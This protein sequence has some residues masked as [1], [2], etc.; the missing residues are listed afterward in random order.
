MDFFIKYKKIFLVVLFLSITLLLGFLIYTLF[1]KSF[2]TP[3]P[4]ETDTG[5]TT[6]RGEFPDSGQGDGGNII[7]DPDRDTELPTNIDT[8]P[9][10]RKIDKTA[11]GGITKTTAITSL[12]SSSVTLDNS[13][14]NLQYYNKQDGKFY[15]IDSQGNAITLSEKVF[16]NV[17]N[18]TWSPAKN[19]AILEYP[20]GANI[21]YDFDSKK[22]ISL[23]KHWEDFDFSV[24]G[25]NIVAKSIGLDPHNR[26][27]ITSNSNG[28]NSQKIEMIGINAD[29]VQSTWS[30]N[31]Q[32]IAT[33][34]EGVDFDRQKVYFVGKNNENFK[35]LTV[36]G[37]DFRSI[38]S[39]KGDKLLYSVYSSDDDMKPSL[40]VVNSSGDKIGSGRKKLN[41]ETW[42]DK[43]T[44]AS[45]D[46]IYCAVPEY[47]EKGA[48]LL[49]KLAENTVDK[50][51]KI[52]TET[53]VKRIIAI[54][55]IDY[56]ISKI[57]VSDDEKHLYFTDSKTET[58]HKINL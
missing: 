34:I 25:S 2:I 28:A 7:K 23:P 49:P 58:I 21:I 57:V 52:N 48:G 46:D 38:W 33:H 10:I 8:T 43:C 13:G 24:T 22:Q 1:F 29:S 3:E 53:G 9:V 31:N 40:W 51:Y 26:W 12:P 30:P 50:I 39:N 36:E 17:E 55:D 44:Y 4:R 11:R 41:I 47:L 18:V 20:D 35:S 5:T 32:I 6:S 15:K 14:K 45:S 37:R 27:L 56:N 19:K 16:H 54:P 42:A